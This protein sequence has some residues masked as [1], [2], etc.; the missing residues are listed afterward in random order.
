MKSNK[1]IVLA[2]FVLEMVVFE[3]RVSERVSAGLCFRKFLFFFLGCF[4]GICEVPC[5]PHFDTSGSLMFGQA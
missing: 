3:D 5:R 1:K 4:L 2:M